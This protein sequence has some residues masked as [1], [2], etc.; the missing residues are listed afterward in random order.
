MFGH[1]FGQMSE[2]TSGQMS[3]Q[4]SGQMSGQKSGQICGEMSNQ[5]G[6]TQQY[7]T[8]CCALV[9]I[10]RCWALFALLC[11]FALFALLRIVAHCCA[12]LHCCALFERLRIVALFP[13]RLLGFFAVF[14]KLWC[15]FHFGAFY[16]HLWVTIILVA[17][18]CI[19]RSFPSSGASNNPKTI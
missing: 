6:R 14:W 5:M 17:K 19:D 11:M 4:I 10:T 12:L 3:G 7:H 16:G 1:T 15:F 13:P 9:R 8:H 18:N 2:Q